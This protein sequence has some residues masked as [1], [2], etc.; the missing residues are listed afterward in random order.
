MVQQYVLKEIFSEYPDVISVKEMQ[1]MLRIGKNKAY[2]LINTGR[3]ASVKIG[4][5][6]CI[7]KT[8]VIKFLT[9]KKNFVQISK[10]LWTLSDTCGSVAVADKKS[11]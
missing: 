2:E 5:K 9:D 6:N 10:C 3:I 11:S 1:K 8:E 4:K 7:P